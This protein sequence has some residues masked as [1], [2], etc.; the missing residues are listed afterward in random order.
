ML[1]LVPLTGFASSDGR[2][3]AVEDDLGVPASSEHP[4]SAEVISRLPMTGIKIFVLR[5]IR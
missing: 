4:V 2:V 3:L 5:N 1:S